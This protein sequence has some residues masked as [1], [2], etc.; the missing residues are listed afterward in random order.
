MVLVLTEGGIASVAHARVQEPLVVV[1]ASCAVLFG[2]SSVFGGWL[3][4]ENGSHDGSSLTGTSVRLA[5]ASCNLDQLRSFLAIAEH[6][7]SK[8]S[9]HKHSSSQLIRHGICAMRLIHRYDA[10]ALHDAVQRAVL[11]D[12]VACLGELEFAGY[13]EQA[14]PHMHIITHTRIHTT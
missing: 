7:A 3:A 5:I 4:G 1:E 2:A 11:L 10:K 8:H 14:R 12:P 6:V 13:F 9:G